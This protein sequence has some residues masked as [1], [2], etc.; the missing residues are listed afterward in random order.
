MDRTAV[1]HFDRSEFGRVLATVLRLVGDIAAAEEAV[2]DA[3]ALALE[4]WPAQGTP[5]NPRAW[6][7][8]TARHKAIDALRRDGSL[9]SSR[10]RLAPFLIVV[11]NHE[12][13]L[14]PF[15]AHL[16]RTATPVPCKPSEF[17]S[18]RTSSV[19]GSSG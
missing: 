2:Q 17:S 10:E 1:E 12:P 18:R 15:A 8:S 16:P 11:S 14:R 7:V 5:A 3:F 13:A 9:R 6:L 4:R 19:P